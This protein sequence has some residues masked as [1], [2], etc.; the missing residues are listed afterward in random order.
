MLGY[1]TNFASM[2][3]VRWYDD[4]SAAYGESSEGG[5]GKGRGA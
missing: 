3:M 5:K 1:Y 4:Y 2:H